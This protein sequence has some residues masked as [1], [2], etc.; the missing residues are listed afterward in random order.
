MKLTSLL[1][2]S[3]AVLV[4][5]SA[6]AADLPA[7]K[8]APAAAVVA[9]PA[10][11]AGFFQLPGSDTCIQFS[12]YMRAQMGFQ[13]AADKAATVSAGDVDAYAA[14]SNTASWRLNVDAR[15]NT[16]IGVVRGYG[17]FNGDTMDQVYVQAGGF[18]AGLAGA[19][20]GNGGGLAFGTFGSHSSATQLSYTA[21]VGAGSVTFAIL[22]SEA[23]ARNNDTG[24]AQM[25]DLALTTSIPMGAATLGLGAVSHQTVGSA[26]G[27]EN[28]YAVGA[29]LAIV[30]A[31]GTTVG[32]EGAY[33]D[34]A[35]G[36]LGNVF[37]AADV[38]ISIS[39][40]YDVVGT[41]TVT[42]TNTGYNLSAYLAQS[43]GKGTLNAIGTY[44]SVND[45]T[46]DT[47]FQ[48]LELN[49]AY[50]VVKG[51][52]VTPAIAYLAAERLT[53]S[54]STTVAYLRIQ[55]DF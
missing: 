9:C 37:E 38:D 27:S 51:L 43:L 40:T 50:A 39:E 12:G 1:L 35:L 7:K 2:S 16:E 48:G 55:R 32:I 13:S 36:Y 30:A 15:S 45:G 29:T 23:N 54:E 41:S 24:V 34:G 11:G 31:P 5:G 42:A 22:D 28:G 17:R 18:T 47:T 3:A 14:Y 26:A 19:W 20:L 6:F 21:S 46:A 4:A 10:F 52:T 8:A 49:Y 53:V 44:T 33:A 25:P